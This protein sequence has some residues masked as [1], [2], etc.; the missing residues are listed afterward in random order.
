MVALPPA[1]PLVAAMSA[2]DAAAATSSSA[3]IWA[4]RLIRDSFRLF[5][6]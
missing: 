4:F 5:I 2:I 3:T 6:V 1:L